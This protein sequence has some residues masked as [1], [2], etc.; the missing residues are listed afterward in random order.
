MLRG[1][2]NFP[3]THGIWAL[4]AVFLAQNDLNLTHPIYTQVTHSIHSSAASTHHAR[5][6][7]RR[8]HVPPPA[9]CPAS[10]RRR[11]PRPTRAD[12]DATRI[13]CS[14]A[15]ATDSLGFGPPSSRS[16]RSHCLPAWVQIHGGHGRTE[17]P[18]TRLSRKDRDKPLAHPCRVATGRDKA[19]GSLLVRG[20]VPRNGGGAAVRCCKRLHLVRSRYAFD[21]FI[22]LSPSEIK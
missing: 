12:C 22:A 19:I 21:S 13:T 2:R 14:S 7:L 11:A 5:A 16:S 1:Y 18:R 9:A 4:P 3:S 6:Y 15:S 17:G 8:P 20:G 10:H